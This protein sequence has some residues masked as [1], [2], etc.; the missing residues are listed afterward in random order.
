MIH[1]PAGA[2][3]LIPGRTSR[4][5]QDVRVAAA[6]AAAAAALTEHVLY[7]FPAARPVWPPVCAATPAPWCARPGWHR[8][9]PRP[10]QVMGVRLPAL[11]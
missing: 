11:P 10:L 5:S 2:V 8:A 7:A 6:A 3:L 1:R 9:R 4:G